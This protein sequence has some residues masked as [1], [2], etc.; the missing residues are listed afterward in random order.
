MTLTQNKDYITTNGE[1]MITQY[2]IENIWLADSFSKA[3]KINKL[4]ELADLYSIDSKVVEKVQKNILENETLDEV[5][6]REE[7][8]ER[9]HW[10][11]FLGTKAGVDLLTIGKVQPENMLPMALLPIDDFRESVKIA[12]ETAR[13]LNDHTKQ[14]E[15]EINND[16]LPD[17]LI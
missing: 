2:Q 13:K 4:Q 17:N 1:N 16:L 10:V 12:V 7:Q 5:M 8:D 15:K 3:R 11:T 6:S 14:A 9:Q